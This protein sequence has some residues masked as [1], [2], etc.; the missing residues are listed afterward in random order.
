MSKAAKHRR[1]PAEGREISAAECGEGRNSRYACPATCEH[2]PFAPANY[3]QYL[4]LQEEVDGKLM[5]RLRAES[6]EARS[7][8]I[9]AQLGKATAEKDILEFHRLINWLF[10]HEKDTNGLTL[11]ER[12][13]RAGM[14]ELKNDQRVLARAKFKSR[15]SL[16]ET[17]RIVNDSQVEAVDLLDTSGGPLLIQDRSLA[18]IACR[19]QAYV[20]WTYPLPYTARVSGAVYLLPE[21][22]DFTPLEV[23]MAAVQYL[24]GPMDQ[25]AAR[26]WIAG[27]LKRLQKSLTATLQ[28][29]RKQMLS[30]LDADF[31]RTAYQLQKPL[32][33][34]RNL[35]DAAPF[36]EHDSPTTHERSEGFSEARVWFESLPQEN[37]A[38]PAARSALGRVLIGQST[39]RLEAIG[40]VRTAAF[41]S[42]FETTMGD[43]VR[44][45]SEQVEDYTK[46]MREDSPEIDVAL[47][48]PRL[49]QQK[50]ALGLVTSRVST[51]LQHGSM[52]SVMSEAM[53]EQD[54]EFLR[55]AVPMLD[56]RTPGEAA[57]DPVL[58]QKLILL[59]KRRIC[60]TDEHN[61][62]K[63]TTYDM[64]W[65]VQELALTEI[66]IPPPP[67]RP[68]PTVFE[69]EE[70]YDD[71]DPEDWD[72]MPDAPA[73]PDRP[74]TRAEA[75]QRI[76]EAAH[77]LKTPEAAKAAMEDSGSE[78]FEYM[79]KL[80]PNSFGEDDRGMMAMLLSVIWFCFV[81]EGTFGPMLDQK[82]LNNELESVL[83]QLRKLGTDTEWD[84][85]TIRSWC[86]QPHL[87]DLVMAQL[88]GIL[89]S[90]GTDGEPVLEPHMP[91]IL[92]VIT[93]IN[94]MDNAM[95]EM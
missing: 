3:D 80:L 90:N 71:E 75:R 1:C 38:M 60:G 86:H 67:P 31:I 35:L 2:N 72:D 27:N 79:E 59:M 78:L 83:A 15:L 64:N 62:R 61:L 26:L 14:K 43:T 77:S 13:E 12:W 44:Y 92:L 22:P 28:V 55:S 51:P 82:R 5:H 57:K 41:R 63:G 53:R 94:E 47:A 66:L 7:S 4:K 21:F 88:Y 25:E 32:A 20:C 70:D 50:Q 42:G 39:W 84:P 18:S 54:A 34:C 74:F 24:A 16:I 17:R 37:S 9:S 45:E 6:S 56:G 87:L 52:D 8:Q 46:T 93:A 10:F 68:R 49:L 23:L 95:R 11:G 29:R 48:I 19:F 58:R 33:E 30:A 76:E 40:K 91:K 36:V 81:P 73:L 65:V 69:D 85:E 89:Q